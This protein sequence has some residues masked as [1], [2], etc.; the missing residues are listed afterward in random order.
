M[1]NP[2][3]GIAFLYDVSCNVRPLLCRYCE[4]IGDNNPKC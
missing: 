4:T 3:V 1:S 2:N